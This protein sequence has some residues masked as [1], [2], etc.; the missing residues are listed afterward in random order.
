VPKAHKL[1]KEMARYV[2]PHGT[3][4]FSSVFAES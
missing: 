3:G 4:Q 1:I 2:L